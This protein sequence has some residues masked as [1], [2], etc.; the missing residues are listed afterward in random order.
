MEKALMVSHIVAGVT[1]LLLGLLNIFNKKGSTVHKLMGKIYVGA[2][3]WICLSAIISILFIRF[4]LFLMVIAV[5]TFHLSFV[6][7]RVVKRKQPGSEKWYDWL[8]S[9]L[10]GVFGMGLCVYGIYLLINQPDYIALGALSLF[11]GAVTFLNGFQEIQFF[12]SPGKVKMKKW[13]LY[14]HISAMGGSYIAAITAFSVQNGNTFL[15]DF[16]HNWLFWVLPAV[17]GSPIISFTIK[18]YKSAEKKTDNPSIA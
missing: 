6:G 18:K 5:L 8:V 1:V 9:V 13:W 15:P 11:F 4:S 2:M 14:N 7:L 16:D 12:R 3:W 17:I 10:T